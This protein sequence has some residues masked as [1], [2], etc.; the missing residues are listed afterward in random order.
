MM[1]CYGYCLWTVELRR[2]GLSQQRQVKTAVRY[3]LAGLI[4]EPTH[5]LPY[6][7]EYLEWGLQQLAELQANTSLLHRVDGV[8]GLSDPLIAPTEIRSWW[9]NCYLAEKCSHDYRELLTVLKQ[10]GFI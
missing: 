4:T 5:D 6:P 1:D 9:P 7:I 8:A 2:P 3:R 10:T